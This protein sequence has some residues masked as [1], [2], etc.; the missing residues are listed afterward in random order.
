MTGEERPGGWV[1]IPDG[2]VTALGDAGEEPEAVGALDAAR[3][4]VAS[5]LVNAPG[6]LTLPDVDELLKRH[7]EISRPRR[8]LHA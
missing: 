6:E 2:L 4:L 7:A 1:A 5:G 3:C 8:G